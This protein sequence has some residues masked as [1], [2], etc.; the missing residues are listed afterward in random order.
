LPGSFAHNVRKHEYGGIPNWCPLDDALET[1][2]AEALQ[3][4]NDYDAGLLNDYGGGAVNWWQDYI[5]YELERC[6]E[7]WRSAIRQYEDAPE[8]GEG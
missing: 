3:T 6:N 4:E 2:I 8:G 5:R 1:N 7:Y